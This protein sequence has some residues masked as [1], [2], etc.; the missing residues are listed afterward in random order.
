MKPELEK[1]KELYTENIKKY[2]FSSK[3][4]GWNTKDCQSLRFEKLVS[5]IDRNRPFQ[6]NELGCGYGALIDYMNQNHLVF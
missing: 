2:G 4:V 3:S 5:M 6:L 1:V